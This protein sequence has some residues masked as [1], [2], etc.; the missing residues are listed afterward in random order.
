MQQTLR[1]QSRIKFCGRDYIYSLHVSF[2]GERRKRSESLLQLY[3]KKDG[4]SQNEVC[5]LVMVRQRTGSRKKNSSFFSIPLSPS[6]SENLVGYYLLQQ[7]N[8]LNILGQLSFTLKSTSW[9]WSQRQGAI[10]L[11][12]KIFLSLHFFRANSFVRA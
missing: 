1:H 11:L 8:L 3:E 2:V 4:L 9:C 5:L 6:N 12:G 10:L 7:P